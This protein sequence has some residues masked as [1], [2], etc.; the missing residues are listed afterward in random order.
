VTRRSLGTIDQVGPNRWYL[1]I[2]AGRDPVT[3]AR[4]RPR[5]TISGSRKQAE[6]ELAR[7]VAENGGQVP[8]TTLPLG[9]YLDTQYLPWA[10]ANV[11]PHTVRKY[12]YGAALLTPMHQI[13][14]ADLTVWHIER[15]L[16]GMSR[17]GLGASAQEV[18]FEVLKRAL[19]KAVVWRLIP[20]DASVGVDAPRPPRYRPQV[21]TPEQAAALLHDVTGTRLDLPVHLALGGGLRRSENVG[22]RWEHVQPDGVQV[23]SG[24]H[25]RQVGSLDPKSETSRRFVYLPD[26]ALA[27]LDRHVDREHDGVRPTEGFVYPGRWPGTA[28]SPTMFTEWWRAA[29]PGLG[30]T[31]PFKDLRHSY[32]TLMLEAGADLKVVSESM[33]H[34]DIAITS[35]FYLR[36]NATQ[37]AKAAAA[38]G[39]LVGHFGPSTSDASV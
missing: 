6:Q 28:M 1:R 31:L 3:G 9:V 23:D 16:L 2:D 17:G 18:G 8:A 29:R 36:P 11:R 26:W 38:L 4:I 30:L 34:S 27:A 22:L 37:R 12:R 13:A 35:G 33:G 15:W 14:L 25:G 21:L 7:M 24:W 32:G 39:D 10:E 20:G 19:R 5:K